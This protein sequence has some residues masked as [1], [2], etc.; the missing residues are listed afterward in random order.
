MVPGRKLQSR[1]VPS[2]HP[3]PV[4]LRSPTP[5]P[6]P[7]HAP[8]DTARV[9]RWV[10]TGR[11]VLATAI[12]VAAIAV[13]RSAPW[14]DTLAVTVAMLCAV[15][16]TAGSWFYTHLQRR[17]I[18]LALLTLQAIVDLGLVTV[19]VHV[20]GGRASQFAALYV[21]V[22][23]AAAILLPTRGALLVS[24][25]ACVLYSGDALLTGSQTLDLTVLLQLGVFAIIT[26]G[27][28]LIGVRLQEAGAGTAELVAE[29]RLVKLQAEDILY[30]IRSGVVTVDEAGTLL[31]ANPA[32]AVLLGLDLGAHMGLPA[33]DVLASRSPVLADALAA[34]ARRRER[35]TRR[36]GSI[37]KPGAEFP[38]GVTTT[39]ATV[40]TG[41]AVDGARPAG[42]ATAT[43]I[44][45]DISDMKRLEELHLRAERLE[46]IAEL[47]ASLAHEIKNPLAA[48]RSAVEQLGR[49]P[50]GDP[51]AGTLSALVVRESDRLSRL[52]SEFLDFARV[53]MTR[54]G[55]VD[56]GTLARD[57]AAL[58]ATHPDRR[59]GVAVECVTP[60][61][62][63]VVQGDDD[64]LHRVVFNLALNAVQAAPERGTVRIEVAVAASD[65]LPTGMSFDHG[66][67]ALR[68]TDDGPGIPL[69]IRDR[70]FDPFCTTKPGGSGLGLAIVHRAIEAH[71]GVVFTDRADGRTRFTVLL[72]STSEGDPA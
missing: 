53:R 30:N 18:G 65:Q 54:V 51:D 25:L 55:P 34:T 31:Y 33:L 57:A 66:A 48:I 9:L 44:F 35:I 13:W 11:L 15:V 26:I 4:R 38:I 39:S 71:R 47:G 14:K 69:D 23:A 8:L 64:L 60:E 32:A 37:S 19:A 5:G 22:I 49:M 10:Y 70:L 3:L 16:L 52:L 2:R 12:F 41:V 28:A 20:T 6:M 61:G 62:P 24:L 17:R 40:A 67:V 58:A 29:L 72:P 43:A 36:E 56:V 50:A 45:Q 1:R 59:P 63:V 7:S 42:T 21:L 68:V 46:G 27:S